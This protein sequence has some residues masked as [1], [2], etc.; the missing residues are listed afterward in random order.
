MTDTA[1]PRHS[2][3]GLFIPFIVVGLV[4][5]GWTGW[6][7]YLA[8][9]V[10]TRLEARAEA[11]RGDG[12]TVAYSDMSTTGWPF[13]ARVEVPNLS[14]A[15][16]SGHAVAAP[17]LVAE[18]NAYEPTRWV[19][20]APDGLTL[21]RA[22]KGKVAVGGD[23]IRASVSGLTQ[24]FP[25]VA[26]ELANARFTAHRDAEPFPIST[27]RR[28]ELYARPPEPVAA[29]AA[30]ATSEADDSVRVLF[31]LIDAEGRSGGP[32]EGLA[33]NGRMTLQIE[34]V[35]EDASRLSGA[36]TAGIFAA[37]T[38]A[39][40]RF[41]DVRGEMSA[42]ESR[43]TLSSAVLSARPDGRLKGTV[44]LSAV[45][46]FP[47][48]AGLAGSGSSAVDRVGAAGATAATAV[49]ER[50]RRDEEPVSLT[51]V[52]RDGRT[53]LGPF[54]LAPAPKLF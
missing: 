27:A 32:V 42:G 22:G 13:R 11:L 47:A 36:D 24:R 2:R 51:L 20:V 50:L 46:P 5:A 39:G 23:A 7:F 3:K 1:P 19:I 25:N 38:E 43:A 4:L 54:A 16:P 9:Q 21:T 35:V 18:A 40:G 33:R 48:I 41:S 31:R 12:W 14:V 29:D 49:T 17:V 53:F 15:T 30:V 28:I 6:W 8:D 45:R 52:F 10:Q 34:G 26:V 37:W 44:A